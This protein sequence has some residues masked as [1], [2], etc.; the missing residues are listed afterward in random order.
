MVSAAPTSKVRPARGRR[1]GDHPRR[2]VDSH[3]TPGRDL[4]GERLRHAA[5]TAADVEQAGDA[6]QVHV[7]QRTT[8]EPLLHRV[9]APV[10]RAVPVGQGATGWRTVSSAH[11]TFPP[12]TA[13]QPQRSATS[14]DDGQAASTEVERPPVC[15][16]AVP[17]PLSDTEIRTAFSEHVDG[18]LERRPCVRHGVR[19]HLGGDEARVGDQQLV[20]CSP[21][22]VDQSARASRPRAAARL[23]PPRARGRTR[24]VVMTAAATERSGP[25]AYASGAT[26][27][28]CSAQSRP[29]CVEPAVVEDR[30]GV[31]AEQV[32]VQVVGQPVPGGL[33]G[34]RTGDVALG[35]EQGDHLAG[36]ANP[37]PALVESGQQGADALGEE[38]HG[39]EP[40]R[41]GRCSG[42]RPRRGG[43][44]VPRPGP[45]GRRFLVPA[46]PV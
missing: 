11:T 31:G 26:T 40:R 29:T 33:E 23:P 32:E 17:G 46:T 5:V 2:R 36:R 21:R 34:Q 10:A 9:D 1:D 38:A 25:D 20:Q 22:V 45:A 37:A 14:D 6:R 19:R 18:H 12:G 13:S 27:S 41:R 43:T 24:S 15:S 39:P 42:S 7:V 30:R 16:S 8:S 28:V 4:L 3:A 44:A 35:P